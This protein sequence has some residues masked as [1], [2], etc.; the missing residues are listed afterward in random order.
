MI[1]FRKWKLF[2]RIINEL[3][4]MLIEFFDKICS[5]QIYCKRDGCIS[6]KFISRI[7]FIDIELAEFQ[8]WKLPLCTM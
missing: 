4:I 7:A 3:L 8:S 1:C 2:I 6:L 5:R